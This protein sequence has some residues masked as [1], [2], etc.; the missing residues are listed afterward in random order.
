MDATLARYLLENVKHSVVFLILFVLAGATELVAL[1]LDWQ[2]V[3][4]IAKPSIMVSLISYYL[5]RAPKRSFIFVGALLFCWAGDVLLLFQLEGE[6][7]FILG[8]VAFLIGHCLYILTCRQ[9]QWTDTKNELMPTQKIRFSFPIVLAGTG[10]IVI[11]FPSLGDLKIPVL[12]YAIVLMLMVMTALFRY[13]KTSSSSFWMVFAGAAVF[14]SSDSLLAFNKFYTAFYLSGLFVMLTY[15]TAQY[16]I[17]EG[18]VK[19]DTRG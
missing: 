16:L 10:L 15:I 11:L 19:H 9:L 6:M 18:V 8:L 1:V 3:H 13:G 17:V 7:F 12:V 4:T 14:M 2:L 5:S